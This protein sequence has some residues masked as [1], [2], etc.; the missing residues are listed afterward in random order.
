M[1][2]DT[3]AIPTD[4][5]NNLENAFEEAVKQEPGTPEGVIGLIGISTSALKILEHVEH[6]KEQ[7]N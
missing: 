1:T 5:I 2:T 3:Y 6:I 7:P 4:L